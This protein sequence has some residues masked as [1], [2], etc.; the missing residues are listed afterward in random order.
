MTDTKQEYWS[1]T[2]RF[3]EAYDYYYDLLVPN[4]GPAETSSGNLLRV[5]SKIYY[6][7]FN[8]GDSYT[9]L[10]ENHGDF[11][12]IMSI[13]DV[14]KTFLKDLENYVDCYYGDYETFANKVMRYVILKTTNR[15]NTDINILSNLGDFQKAY[16]YFYN[17]LVMNESIDTRSSYGKLLNLASK[18]VYR[19]ILYSDTYT[20][21]V[22][23]GDESYSLDSIEGLDK[24]LVDSLEKVLNL[25]NDYTKFTNRVLRH[26]M[27]EHSTPESIWNPTTNRLVSI[28]GATGMKCLKMLDC[29]ITYKPN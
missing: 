25:E 4:S 11:Y 28:L 24:E 20:N 26:I 15:W 8:D 9:D 27:L 23:D 14:D 5:M 21:L 6:R 22:E 19:S 3:Q 7:H 13:P 17:K 16:D 18:I 1:G 10:L 29:S 2:G 12:N